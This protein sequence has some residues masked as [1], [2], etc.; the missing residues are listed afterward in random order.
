V[1]NGQLCSV[2]RYLARHHG[3]NRL[4][5]LPDSQ[6]LERFLTQRDEPAFEVLLWRH[7][8][9][10]LERVPARARHDHDAEDAFQ[11]TFLTLA[12]RAGSIGKRAAVASWLYKVAYR[13]ALQEARPHRPARSRAGPRLRRWRRRKWSWTWS[14]RDLRPVLDEELNRPA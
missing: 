7:G 13:I 9:I 14:G 10:G 6:L 2:L 1:V 3:G 8:T 11:A 12:R 5:A 4:G